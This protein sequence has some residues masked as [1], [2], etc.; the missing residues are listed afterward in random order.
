MKYFLLDKIISFEKGISA[1]AVKCISYSDEILHD[2]F[3]DFPVMPGALLVE[4]SAQL[5]SFLFEM[6]INEKENKTIRRSLLVQIN[7]AKF[8]RFAEPGDKIILSAELIDLS[9]SSAHCKVLLEVEK[10]KVASMMLTLVSR[11]IQSESIHDQRRRIYEVWTRNLNPK[12][13]IV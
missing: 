4:A 2:H 12:P 3:P 6:S 10:E 8:H 7:K 11:N 5:G 9:I 13:D 1:K